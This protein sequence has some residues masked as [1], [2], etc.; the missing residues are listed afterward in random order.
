[1]LSKRQLK[2]TFKV[3]AASTRLHQHPGFRSVW[4]WSSFIFAVFLRVPFLWY[5]WASRLSFVL[6]PR[7]RFSSGFRA[8]PQ[9]RRTAARSAA[10]PQCSAALAGF[11]KRRQGTSLLPTSSTGPHHLPHTQHFD[12]LCGFCA[13]LL[14]SQ[15]WSCHCF[16]VLLLSQGTFCKSQVTVGLDLDEVLNNREVCKDWDL[17]V[18]SLPGPYTEAH[19]HQEVGTLVRGTGWLEGLCLKCVTP[20]KNELHRERLTEH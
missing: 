7:V 4:G 3:T 14:S 17:P 1:M 12:L 5:T 11:V 6:F 20:P 18:S 9:R 16:Q 2:A 15:L 10:D 13:L 8:S 19:P